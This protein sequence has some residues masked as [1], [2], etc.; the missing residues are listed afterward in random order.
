LSDAENCGSGLARDGVIDSD[1]KVKVYKSTSIYLHPFKRRLTSLSDTGI[2]LFAAIMM[3]M[4]TSC[5]DTT[6][7]AVFLLIGPDQAK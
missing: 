1:A 5:C 3:D 7:H 4:R 6:P 2:S